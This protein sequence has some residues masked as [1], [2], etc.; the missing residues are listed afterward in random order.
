MTNVL[1]PTPKQKFFTNNGVPAAGY[2]LFTYGAGGSVKTAT[3]KDQTTGSPNTNPIILDFRGEADIWIPPNV[4]YKYVFALPAD[5]DPPSNP[6]WT[7]DNLVNSQLITLYGGVD[8]GS[9]N[10]YVLNFVA[11]FTA[12]ADGIVIYFIAANTNT[13][14]STINVNGL[15][16]VAITRQDGTPLT[17]GQIVAN[18]VTQIMYKGAGFLLLFSSSLIATTTQTQN[19]SLTAGNYTLQLTD[20]GASFTMSVGA[21]R[22]LTIPPNASVAFPLGTLEYLYNEGNADLNI[23]RGAGVSLYEAGTLIDADG[24]LPAGSRSWATIYK[25]STNIWLVFYSMRGGTYTGTLTGV[26]GTIT[27]AI[28]WRINSGM[29][30][31]NVTANLQG[32]SNST[33]CTIT[34]MPAFLRPANDK[35]ATC[36]LLNNSLVDYGWAQ[37]TT[38]GVIAF[39]VGFANNPA[40]FTAANNKGISILWSV[41]Y[42]LV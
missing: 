22:N 38:L 10:A 11:N 27:G 20:Q 19:I 37:V 12:Y 2:K 36:T 39:G 8:T 23:V 16:P 18:Q 41:S 29:I 6:L 3:Y 35:L 34:G 33:A 15:G 28:K 17:A 31:L 26:V 40:G 7:I 21:N 9:P 25:Y 24:L 1:T 4:A 5:T 30:H 42:P 32:T 13:G 14:P